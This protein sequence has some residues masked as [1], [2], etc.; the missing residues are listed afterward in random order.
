MASC[1]VERYRKL[2]SGEAD[3]IMVP[4]LKQCVHTEHEASPP[5]AATWD[6]SS[7]TDAPAEH[8]RP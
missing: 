3:D 6:A 5:A 8:S 1:F 4:Q 7:E 2:L